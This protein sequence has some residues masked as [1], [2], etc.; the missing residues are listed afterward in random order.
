MKNRLAVAVFMAANQALYDTVFQDDPERADAFLA[1]FEDHVETLLADGEI[2]TPYGG[3]ISLAD[4][5]EGGQMADDLL[6]KFDNQNT[7]NEGEGK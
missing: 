2:E 3:P 1:R 5:N 7:C 4:G 6:A